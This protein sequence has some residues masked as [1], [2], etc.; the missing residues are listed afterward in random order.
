[1]KYLKPKDVILSIVKA[2]VIAIGIYFGVNLLL[3][4]VFSMPD[5]S[6]IDPVTLKQFLFIN[7]V[8]VG[9]FIPLMIWIFIKDRRNEIKWALEEIEIAKREEKER[10][11]WE[12][13]TFYGKIINDVTGKVV[14]AWE[15]KS[16]YFQPKR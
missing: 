10:R 2:M 5:L 7:G 1:M 14:E 8:L 6:T 12:K 16:R 13:H 4:F 15:T 3:Y 11:F 9:A